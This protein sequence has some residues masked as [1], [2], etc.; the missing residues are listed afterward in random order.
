MKRKITAVITA[1]FMI[2]IAAMLPGGA[3][4][5]ARAAGTQNW[6]EV[7]T[8]GLSDATYT[9]LAFDAAGT[10]YVAYPSRS[11]AY[12]ATVVKYNGRNWETVC[13]AGFSRG[14]ATQISLAFNG[15]TPYVAYRDSYSTP[16]FF[17]IRELAV[18]KFNGSS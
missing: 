7:D 16:E 13:T 18:M 1:V 12:K 3:M 14:S 17:Y 5:T 6:A 2:I 9:S 4:Q 15:N 11:N 8:A 10:P